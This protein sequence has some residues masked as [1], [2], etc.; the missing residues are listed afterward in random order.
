MRGALSV[1]TSVPSRIASRCKVQTPPSQKESIAR[2]TVVVDAELELELELERMAALVSRA[3][4]V[5]ALA[6][7]RLAVTS[8]D[9]AR[10][11]AS[12]WQSTQAALGELGILLHPGE[13]GPEGESGP[14]GAPVLGVE[15][16]GSS[17]VEL[18]SQALD[19]ITRMASEEDEENQDVEDVD[20][21]EMAMMELYFTVEAF[22][23]VSPSTCSYL[24]LQA[25]FDQR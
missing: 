1:D 7:L 11:A 24:G 5:L 18:A 14:A 25:S 23:A 13:D 19:D 15:A 22:A 3:L 20:R 8:A 12:A 17:F 10:T 2:A 16:V 21:C 6:T 4:E 9:R